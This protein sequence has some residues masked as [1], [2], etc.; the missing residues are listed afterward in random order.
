MLT[1]LQRAYRSLRNAQAQTDALV[2]E[3]RRIA[4]WTYGPSISSSKDGPMGGSNSASLRKLAHSFPS[5]A[6]E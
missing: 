6:H 5:V 1:P 3:G 4:G 2:A